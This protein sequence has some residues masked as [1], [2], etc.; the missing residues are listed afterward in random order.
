MKGISLDDRSTPGGPALV[1]GI[2]G[3]VALGVAA[4]LALKGVTPETLGLALRSTAR[5]S[6]ALLWATFSA[7][8]LATLFGI[9][10]PLRQ[11]RYLGLAFGGVHLVHGVLVL[12]LAF[13]LHGGDLTGLS[14]A[15]EVAG[16]VFVYLVIVAMMV[17]SRDG[18][19]R[20]LGVTRWR[21]LHRFGI[22]LLFLVFLLDYAKLAIDGS[23]AHWVAVG[24]FLGAWG[25]R[26][27]ARRRGRRHEAA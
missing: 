8:A 4:L 18:A 10:W 23:L 3:A 21:R 17:T 14:P 24:A 20:A 12:T 7:S 27:A 16:G 15:P 22:W 19:V 9:T 11:R 26:I 1:A 5:I 6:S 13:R 25:L 2:V